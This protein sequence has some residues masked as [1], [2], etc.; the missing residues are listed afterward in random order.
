MA[1]RLGFRTVFTIGADFQIE[2]DHQYAWE[3]NIKEELINKNKRLYSKTVKI[4]EDLK[5]HFKEH[6]FRVVNCSPTSML[7]NAFNFIKINSYKIDLE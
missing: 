6:D 4:M 7:K 1:H 2:V 3:T 5:P